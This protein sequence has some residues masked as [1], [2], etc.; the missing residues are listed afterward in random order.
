[1]GDAPDPLSLNLTT[2]LDQAKK[3]LQKAAPKEQ[4]ATTLDIL[5]DCRFLLRFDI[6]KMP[7]EIAM[8]LA[9]GN[10]DIL[11]EARTR[12]YWPQVVWRKP[13]R[14][15]LLAVITDEHQ[16]REEPLDILPD[17]SDWIH[18]D[19]IRTLDAT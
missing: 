12:W 18:I 11:V 6:T 9:V 5:Y 1:M 19:W 17:L 16:V 2:Q 10:S 14:T 3:E 4:A 8:S 15:D 13:G 7:P